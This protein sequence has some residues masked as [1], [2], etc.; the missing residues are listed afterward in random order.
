MRRHP[1]GVWFRF[2]ARQL[3]RALKVT[4]RS[5]WRA[6][7]YLMEHGEWYGFEWVTCQTDGVTGGWQVLVAHPERLAWDRKPLFFRQ[8]GTSRRLKSWARGEVLFS[9]GSLSL[10]D[11]G[12]QIT[13]QNALT[14][15]SIRPESLQAAVSVNGETPF[16]TVGKVHR[17]EESGWI[18]RKSSDPPV[19]KK[20]Q[21]RYFHALA[22]RLGALH[23]DNCAV[24]YVHSATVSVV[25][26][27]LAEGAAPSAIMAVYF[28]ALESAHRDA[29]DSA[30]GR[31]GNQRTI[32][33]SRV[34]A[35]VYREF[36]FARVDTGD[37]V[38]Y[39]MV[40]EDMLATISARF[41][42]QYFAACEKIRCS[43]Q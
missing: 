5:I 12:P 3:S 8:D 4:E 36:G 7:A 19:G 43:Y 20:R 28:R 30:L 42:R 27:L 38:I 11:S 24:R 16:Q 25:R 32:L 26:S 31:E 10:S 21:T 41:R 35:E 6:K 29:T 1:S 22:R 18:S 34:F 37:G 33:P 23:W 39:V 9:S 17:D 40:Y 15:A 14:G 2:D 13:G